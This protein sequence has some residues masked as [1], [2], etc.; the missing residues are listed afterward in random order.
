MKWRYTT[1]ASHPPSPTMVDQ[2]SPTPPRNVL[3]PTD[4][5]FPLEVLDIYTLETSATIPCSSG[6]LPIHALVKSGYLGNSPVTPSLA[7]SLR[8]LEL[9]W[10]I[11]LRKSSFSVEAFAKVVCDLYSASPIYFHHS[12]ALFNSPNSR[13]HIAATAVLR[14]LRHL[15][16][17]SQFCSLLRNWLVRSLDAVLLLNVAKP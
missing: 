12:S 14:L 17:M 15:K 7:I 3:P 11:W 5:G 13:S 1:T 4:S 2:S 8:T 10:R 9:L 6:D 16:S